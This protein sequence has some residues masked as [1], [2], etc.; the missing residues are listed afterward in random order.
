MDCISPKTSADVLFD[1]H[2]VAI[3]REW[4]R[5]AKGPGTVLILET[6][7]TGMGVST[8]LRLLCGELGIE[9]IAI[10]TNIPKLKTLLKDASG[11]PF[12]VEGLKKIMIVDPLD[13]VLAEPTCATDLS[14]FF[15]SKAPIPAIVAGIRLRSSLAKL[16]DM[17][18]P[19]VY[20]VTTLT[21]KAIED[22]I[23]LA[24]LEDIKRR[25][26]KRVNVKDVWTGDLRNALAALDTD[27]PRSIKDDHC[28]G[29][30]AVAR[31]LF[32][33][34]LT[35]RDSIA[36][37]E[38]DVSMITAGTHENY[39]HTGQT[40]ETCARMADVY[41]I[42]DAMDEHMYTT[43]RWELGD[44]CTAISSGGPVA[45]LDKDAGAAHKHIDLSKFGTIWSR[46]NNQRTKEKA[47]RGIRQIMIEHG[48]CMGH[49]IESIATIRGMMMHAVK[50]DEWDHV[51]RIVNILPPETVL[52]IMRLWKSGYT[53]AHHG[54]YKK[55]RLS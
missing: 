33:K 26:N 8:L 19:K 23:A 13:A 14:E 22:S 46:N 11:S 35:I 1:A 45:Y 29:V 43:Q 36:M 18:S 4:M 41:S 40:I 31:V 20:S 28:D 37:H 39:P 21:F 3:C 53:Q 9:P 16:G 42:T 7:H 17:V 38:G 50:R 49:H 55:K 6:P 47:L 32:E 5:T 30:Q 24:Y 25:H 12:T 48:M 10:S 44:V 51:S 52:A 2:D 15:K 54:V 27:V 34:T